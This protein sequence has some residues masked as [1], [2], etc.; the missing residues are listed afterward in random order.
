M[1]ST[2]VKASVRS[3]VL[4]PGDVQIQAKRTL[5]PRI[6]SIVVR[7]K[8][9]DEIGVAEKISMF[10]GFVIIMYSYPF[11]VLAHLEDYRRGNK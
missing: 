3:M 5:Y 1:I 6:K 4:K 2:L 8:T 11:W 10:V 7:R 9:P